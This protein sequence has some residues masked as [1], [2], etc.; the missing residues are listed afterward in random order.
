[1]ETHAASVLS[2]NATPHKERE[3]YSPK[4]RLLCVEEERKVGDAELIEGAYGP[5]VIKHN[6]VM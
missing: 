2:A 5:R 3:R 6:G 4:A 1:M